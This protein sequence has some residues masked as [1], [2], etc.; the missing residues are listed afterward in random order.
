MLRARLSMSHSRESMPALSIFLQSLREE[1]S[2][3]H[4]Y[5]FDAVCIQYPNLMQLQPLLSQDWLQ[6]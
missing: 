5:I 6:T 3:M 2:F 1:A 4:P